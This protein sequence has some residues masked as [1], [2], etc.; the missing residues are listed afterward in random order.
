MN[1]PKPVLR[2]MLRRYS[3]EALIEYIVELCQFEDPD[4]T[5]LKEIEAVLDR[6]AV[7]AEA[8]ALVRDAEAGCALAWN[9]LNQLVRRMGGGA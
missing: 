5:R 3:P 2:Q 4:F 7:A 9:R 6:D 8:D 1:I